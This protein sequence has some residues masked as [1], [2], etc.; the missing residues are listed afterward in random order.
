MKKKT[1]LIVI[2]LLLIA[3]VFGYNY[4]YQDHR[5]ISTES[6]AYTLNAEDLIAEFATDTEIAQSKYLNK[7]ILINGEITAQR[8]SSVTLNNSI[9][10]S[11][12]EQ[13]PISEKRKIS[14]KGRFIGYDDLLEEIKLDQ[15]TITTN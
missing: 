15:C 13:N 14:V 3:A 12:L 8:N 4:V 5:D 11:L 9:F 6:A 7:T 10:C 2:I 1:L